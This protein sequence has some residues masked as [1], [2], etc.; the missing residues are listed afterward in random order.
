[1]ARKLPPNHNAPA[2]ALT[3][4]ANAFQRNVFVAGQRTQCVHVQVYCV[5]VVMGAPQRRRVRM[6]A[7][8]QA[9]RLLSAT[10]GLLAPLSVLWR[11]LA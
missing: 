10:L 11:W 3:V 7:V 2:G 9:V 6:G 5:H 4:P 1:M 8:T